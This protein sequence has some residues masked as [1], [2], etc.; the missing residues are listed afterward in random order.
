MRR[1][2]TLGIPGGGGVP[3]L[4]G[5]GARAQSP[6]FPGNCEDQGP[7]KATSPGTFKARPQEVVDIPSKV[8]GRP[9]QIG[10]IRP[11]APAGYRAPVVVHAGPYHSRDLKD[12]DLASC[13]KFLVAN[14]VS[15][16]YAV[17]I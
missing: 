1:R 14:F 15:H 13:A 12:A 8:D 4:P 7:S 16:G 17:A 9:L 5:P 3:A 2:A 11:D 10:F 6:V